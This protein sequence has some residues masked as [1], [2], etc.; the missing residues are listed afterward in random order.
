VRREGYEGHFWPSPLQ[1]DLLRAALL[2]PEEA[3]AAWRALRPRLDLDDVWDPEVHRI[4]PLVASRLREAGADDPDLPRLQG[5]ARRTWYEN[6]LRVDR[7]A[8]VIGALEEAGIATLLL[9]GM[10]LALRYYESVALRPMSDVDVLVP[11]RQAPEAMALLGDGGWTWDP[12]F[13]NHF[14]HGVAMTRREE[15][16]DLHWHLGLPFILADDEPGSDD[17]FWAAAE[18]LALGEIATRTLDPTDM[19]LHVCVHGGWSDSA[20]TVRWV[21]DAMTV[22]RTAGDRIDWGRLEE[23]VRRRRL[24]LLVS[25]PLRYLA[26][27]VGAPV[28]AEVR[29]RIA[30]MPTSARER[31][32]RRRSIGPVGGEG[33]AGR[34]RMLAAQWGRTSAGWSRARALRE[35]P[36]F[37]QQAWSLDSVWAVP[38]T[39]VRKVSRR[40]GTSLRVA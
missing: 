34:T 25:E 15:T 38:T 14:H 16:L 12:R 4:L 13:L 5:L 1:E 37:L 39:A 27:V 2:G 30:A 18:P 22:L 3:A 7:A 26:E 9:K 29:A 33:I 31:A 35:L 20:A 23:H 8:P 28:P 21:A 36:F 19:L 10:P 40:L 17:A 32:S 6:Q 11:T 24:T